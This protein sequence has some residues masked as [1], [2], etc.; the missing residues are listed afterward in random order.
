MKS[1]IQL[2]SIGSHEKKRSSLRL[3]F[4]IFILILIVLVVGSYYVF[5]RDAIR[6]KNVKVSELAYSDSQLVQLN[7][8]GM[9]GGSYLFGLVPKNSIFFYPKAEIIKSLSIPSIKSVSIAINSNVLN[10]TP[11][12]R[13][14]LFLWCSSSSCDYVDDSG[15][16]FAVAPEIQG[17]A[18]VIFQNGSN[19]QVGFLSAPANDIKTIFAFLNGIKD[20][21]FSISTFAISQREA[22]LTD[23]SGM[24]F[25]LNL[26]ESPDESL[27]YLKQMLSSTE[28]KNFDKTKTEYIDLRF[29]NKILL[30]N[31]DSGNS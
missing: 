26:D 22:D 8:S 30:K 15:L 25:K 12:E 29:E 10:I 27:Y 5:H 20:S 28:L 24:Y 17:N 18:Y 4:L 7:I 2:K 1:R 14:P 11:T 16:A 19:P 23:A 31:K 13:I 21:G 6:I 9:L 3:F